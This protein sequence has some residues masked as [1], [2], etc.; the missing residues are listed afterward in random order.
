MHQ[1]KIK[2]VTDVSEEPPAYISRRRQVP[3]KLLSLSPIAEVFDLP[4]SRLPWCNFSW[5]LFF[6]L[7]GVFYD[8]SAKLYNV[9]W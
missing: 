4:C 6:G 3:P 8:T 2:I 5:T 9:H 1:P 7:G